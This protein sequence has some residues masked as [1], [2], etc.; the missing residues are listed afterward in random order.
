MSR[1]DP[2]RESRRASPL[3]NA[4]SEAAELF[5]SQVYPHATPATVRLLVH[6]RRVIRLFLD[7]ELGRPQTDSGPGIKII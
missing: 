2:Y 5:E 4:E 6:S 1:T 3:Q 7:S